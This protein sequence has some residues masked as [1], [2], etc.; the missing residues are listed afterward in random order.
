MSVNM[1]LI[2]FCIS[3]LIL[4][5]PLLASF[6]SVESTSNFLTPN[7]SHETFESVSDDGAGSVIH[8]TASYDFT[9]GQTITTDSNNKN[10][11]IQQSSF[12]QYKTIDGI[13][14]EETVFSQADA[15]SLINLST[16]E[17]KNIAE[18]YNSGGASSVVANSKTFY[19]DLISFDPRDYDSLFQLTFNYEGRL[20]GNPS[21][22]YSIKAFTSGISKS[23]SD[24]FS[25]TNFYSERIDLELLIPK[26]AT[27]IDLYIETSSSAFGNGRASFEDTSWFNMKMLDNRDLNSNV[28]NLLSNPR[29]NINSV[30]VSEP[31]YTGLLFIAVLCYLFGLRISNRNKIKI[32]KYIQNL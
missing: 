29:A 25:Q 19:N 13:S 11:Q 8:N 16:G 23:L 31:K 2:I 15:F 20:L 24:S 14:K 17:F 9:N 12:C 27:G 4:P 1:K 26:G 5:F 22:G 7:C 6:I 30:K 18:T 10:W 32:Q 28:T 21:F 3:V